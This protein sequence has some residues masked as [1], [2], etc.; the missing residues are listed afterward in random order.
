MSGPAAGRRMRVRRKRVYE[1]PAAADGFRILVDRVWPRGVSRQA[2]HVDVW[3]K[4]V[5][6]TT[7]LRKWFAHDAGKWDEFRRRYFRELDANEEAVATLRS[8]LKR[9]T[10]TLVY[11]AKDE[12]HNQ[13]AALEEY[14]AH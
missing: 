10:V 8:H 1:A 12:R 9:G 7:A 11:S 5:A 13:A 6:P 3:L 14:L 4:E 2:A